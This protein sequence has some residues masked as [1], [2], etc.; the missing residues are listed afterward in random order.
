MSRSY[1]HTPYCGDKKDKFFKRYANR[2]LRKKK[3]IHD[4]QHKSY[5]KDF[6]PYTICDYYFIE[7]RNFEDY[8]RREVQRW[9]RW[10]IYSWGK[11]E[12]FPTRE[13]VWKEYN[14]WYVRK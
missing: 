3:L 4:Y 10:G 12:P 9:Q 13:E 14:K 7:T 6:E 8:Y 5:R 2:R 1:K 11:K